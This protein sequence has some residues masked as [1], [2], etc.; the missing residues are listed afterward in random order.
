MKENKE[1]EKLLLD[2]S[3]YDKLMKNKIEKEFTKELE[4]AKSSKHKFITDIKAVP[5]GKLFTKDTVFEIINKNSKTRS[6]ITG[7]QAEGFLG[8]KYSDREKLL[9]GE[10][11]S[12]VNGN[13]FIK[14]VKVKI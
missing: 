10:I 11:D 3:A 2:D 12:F 14:F 1:I 9:K 6:F 4:A 13:N 8:T 7:V 5:G